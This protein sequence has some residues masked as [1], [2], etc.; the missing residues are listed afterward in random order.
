MFWPT[1]LHSSNSYKQIR[2]ESDLHQ[3]FWRLL[4]CHC[5]TDLSVESVRIELTSRGFRPRVSTKSTNF[6]YFK[7]KEKPPVSELG[8]FRKT[9]GFCHDIWLIRIYEVPGPVECPEWSDNPVSQERKRCAV[10]ILAKFPHV[11]WNAVPIKPRQF[12]PFITFVVP[13]M[14]VMMFSPSFWICY[15]KSL[16]NSHDTSYE[17]DRHFL[18]MRLLYHMVLENA[19]TFCINYAFSDEA[20]N[21][22]PQCGQSPTVPA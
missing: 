5:T 20:F 6:P 11:K 10:P 15:K 21:G 14:A 18:F 16:Y 17:S 22:A 1:E 3:E 4:C 13:I 9:D 19:S 8:S 12:V 2:Q 7:A